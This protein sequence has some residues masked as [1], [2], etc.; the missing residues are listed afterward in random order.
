[1]GAFRF[2]YV[3]FSKESGLA[4]PKLHSSVCLLVVFLYSAES[5]N[6]SHNLPLLWTIT[7]DFM[8]QHTRI[9][10]VLRTAKHRWDHQQVINLLKFVSC[11][12]FVIVI[13]FSWII[14]L[15]VVQVLSSHDILHNSLV[16]ESINGNYFSDLWIN[17]KSYNI[18]SSS[19]ICIFWGPPW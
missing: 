12:E 13:R 17:E 2:L 16:G 8:V 9:L 18:F 5:A 6:Y 3:H 7:G 4:G 14:N 1:M 10:V 19:V 11:V 15:F